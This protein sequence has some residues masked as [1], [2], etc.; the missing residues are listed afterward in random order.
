MAVRPRPNKLRQRLQPPDRT[1]APDARHRTRERTLPRE[2]ITKNLD[3]GRSRTIDSRLW[4]RSWRSCSKKREEVV[5]KHRAKNPGEPCP[6]PINA[7]WTNSRS[8]PTWPVR[9]R[10]DRLRSAAVGYR[11]RPAS[12][13]K[14]WRTKRFVGSTTT[15][16]FWSIRP[17]SSARRHQGI[18]ARVAARPR[19]ESGSAQ[20]RR[21][22]SPWP[23]WNGPPCPPAWI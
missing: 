10:P 18:L 9:V 16:F 14:L 17:S 6:K 2:R 11:E 19:R 7:S 3:K 5:D 15:C 4:T 13:G 20:R 1:H 12:R 8:I 23:P 22:M 21:T